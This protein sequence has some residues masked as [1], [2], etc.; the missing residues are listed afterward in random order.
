M[1]LP[2]A[3]GAHGNASA[4]T[5]RDV[6]RELGH[7]FGGLTAYSRA[8]AQGRWRHDGGGEERDDLVVVEGMVE[9]VEP[10]SW[11]SF[12][13]RWAAGLGQDELVVRCWEIRTS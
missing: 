8:P 11:S 10:E 1:L 13:S 7:T 2:V 9:R 3:R 6:T 4:T 5:L 12:R